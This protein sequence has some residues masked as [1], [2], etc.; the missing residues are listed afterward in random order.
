MSAKP[1]LAAPDVPLLIEE[2][3][4][5]RDCKVSILIILR[6]MNEEMGPMASLSFCYFCFYSKAKLLTS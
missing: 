4:Y 6:N 3:N 2:G 5:A 1:S